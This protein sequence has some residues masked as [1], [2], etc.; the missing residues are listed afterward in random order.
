MTPPSSQFDLE[1]EA[2]CFEPDQPS[3]WSENDFGAFVDRHPW[4]FASTMPE[5][6]HEYTLRKNASGSIFEAAVRYIREHGTLEMFR[7]RPYKTLYF[8]DHKFWTM[9]YPLQ[10]T[11]LINRKP[12]AADDAIVASDAKEP[13]CS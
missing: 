2:T 12:R 8:R 7:G 4:R 5:N 11:E 1:A 10:E 6:P 3:G 13:S 9:G